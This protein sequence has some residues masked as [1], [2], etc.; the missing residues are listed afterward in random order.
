[1]NNS[2]QS[3]KNLR[4]C[5]KGHKYYKSSSC[6]VCPMCDKQN[7]PQEGFLSELSAPA[8]RALENA[9]ITTLH[10]LSQYNESEILEL[11]GLGPSTIPTLRKAL[12]SEELAFAKKT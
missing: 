6:P 3:V 12:K 8:R 2:T 7:A 1:M 9:G 5:S 10:K 4:V 11:H